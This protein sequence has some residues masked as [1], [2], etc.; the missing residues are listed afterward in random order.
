[1][2]EA[3]PELETKRLLNKFS[4]ARV[5][6]SADIGPIK[7]QGQCGGC[8]AFAGNS[9]VNYAFN[10]YYAQRPDIKLASE[11]E[12]IECSLAYRNNGCD[13]GWPHQAMQYVRFN[14]VFTDRRYRYRYD[15]YMSGKVM[16]CAVGSGAAKEMG[17]DRSSIRI[18]Q[19][20]TVESMKTI[21]DHHKVAAIG[22]STKSPNLIFYR[23]GILSDC[24][25]FT[26]MDHA[27]TNVGYLIN[28]ERG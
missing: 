26:K 22:I 16:D 10:K 28:L 1:M 18:S 8:Y 21:I 12:I 2:V 5:N 11:Q 4:N 13:G 24:G 7:A 9:V 3:R 20:N 15:T 17:I 27:V 25:N 19:Y 6:N 14:G 23:S